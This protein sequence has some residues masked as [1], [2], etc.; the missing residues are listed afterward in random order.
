M[1][2]RDGRRGVLALMLVSAFLVGGASAPALA[3]EAGV[4]DAGTAQDIATVVQQDDASDVTGLEFIA[5]DNRGLTLSYAVGSGGER[6]YSADALF[7]DGDILRVTR[8]T[9]AKDYVYAQ[10]DGGDGTATG[11]FACVDD[12]EDVVK[13][14][15]ILRVDVDQNKVDIAY[16]G[17]TI[18]VQAE[19]KEDLENTAMTTQNQVSSG[20]WGTCPWRLMGDGRLIIEPGTGVNETPWYDNFDDQYSVTRVEAVQK[21]GSKVIAP[22]D[23]SYLFA[24]LPDVTSMD[25]SGMDTSQVRNMLGMF[26]ND[27][28][29]SALDISTWNTS[30]V[31]NMGLMFRGCSKLGFIDVER[32]DTGRVFNMQNMFNGCSS[33]KQLAVSNWNVSSVTYAPYMF[34][35]CSQIT[36][37]DL[38]KWNTSKM[39]S[40]AAMFGECSS[41]NSLSVSGWNTSRAVSMALMFYQCK[42]L[43]KLD[44]SSFDMSSIVEPAYLRGQAAGDGLTTQDGAEYGAI[45]MFNSCTSLEELEVGSKYRTELVGAVPAATASNGKWW[46]YGAQAWLAPDQIAQSRSRIAD[47]YTSYEVRNASVVPHV[48]Y[49]THVQRVGWQR[50][51]TDGSMSG[52]SGRSL[53]LEGINVKVASLPCSGGI[54]YRTHVQRIGWQGW[55]LLAAP[56]GHPD[57]ARAQGQVGPGPRVQ[58]HNAALLRPVQAEGQEVAEELG[59]RG[60]SH[61]P[62]HHCKTYSFSEMRIG[63]NKE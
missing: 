25:L 34:Y 43:K 26:S 4:V 8:G 3:D 6:E 14:S 35:G 52:T 56:G 37:L 18:S 29:L 24:C 42:S 38:S 30:N 27:E 60:R 57:R 33:L 62:S 36:A 49:R 58:G 21:G 7:V 54:Q 28:S 13:A 63:I 2:W 51:V 22:V 19:L 12:A 10:Q 47:T 1:R 55:R 50:Y 61:Q 59:E 46:S 9:E 15:D 17:R 44:L 16:G 39:E 5:C 31:E 20:T 40:M 32:F 23:S 45:Q 48:S 11:V 41:L 53:R